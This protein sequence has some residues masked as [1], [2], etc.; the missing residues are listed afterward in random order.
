MEI[1]GG[2]FTRSN[3]AILLDIYW[4]KRKPHFANNSHEING[5]MDGV[6]WATN[7]RADENRFGAIVQT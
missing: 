7:T 3:P 6:T 1:R 4:R 2:V 5:V